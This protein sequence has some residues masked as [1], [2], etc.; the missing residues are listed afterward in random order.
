MLSEILAW[1]LKQ[2]TPL[3]QKKLRPFSDHSWHDPYEP[4]G[5]RKLNAEGIDL[6]LY[7]AT[8]STGLVV[9]TSVYDPKSQSTEI[10]IYMITD[11]QSLGTELE[12]IVV[13]ESLKRAS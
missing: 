3:P 7:Q 13:L 2:L 12:R 8:D 9:E 10:R 6:R 5:Q 1:A 11:Q 4:V